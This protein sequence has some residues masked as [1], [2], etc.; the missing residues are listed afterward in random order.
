MKFDGAIFEED[1]LILDAEFCQ[2]AT[3]KET[4]FKGGIHLNRAKFMSAVNFRQSKFKGAVNFNFVLFGEIADFSKAVFSYEKT[5]STKETTDHPKLPSIIGG[6]KF[7]GANF[8]K[9]AIFK[10]HALKM[11]QIFLARV[12]EKAWI[13]LIL[14]LEVLYFSHPAA[15]KLLW[16]NSLPILCAMLINSSRISSLAK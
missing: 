10:K 3:F 12:L 1:L 5:P 2:S 6:V 9:E 8:V 7:Y 13:L 16:L 15:R 14:I 11:E 4:V